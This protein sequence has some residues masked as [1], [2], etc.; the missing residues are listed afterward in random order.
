MNKKIINMVIT[1][2][3]LAGMLNATSVFAFPI[4]TDWS[5][6]IDSGF[7]SWTNSSNSTI[8]TPT[9][10]VGTGITASDVN[11][12]LSDPSKLSWGTGTNGQSSLSVG[13]ASGGNVQ[14]NLLTDAAAVNTVKLIHNNQPING[15]TLT[16]AVLFDQIVL[17]ATAPAG[18]VGTLTPN[19]TL[20]FLIN[21]VE[22]PNATP[23]VAPSPSGNPCNDI[24]V[25]DVQ[26]AGFNP[27]NQ[28][29]NQNF[30]YNG[31]PYNAQLFIS[32]LNFLTAAECSTAGSSNSHCLGF[33][34]IEG[35]SNNFQ[36]SLAITTEQF[37]P[38]PEPSILLL[39]GAGLCGMGW[40]NSR[41]QQA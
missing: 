13:S 30:F 36:V 28:S 6:T 32:G 2:I 23:C 5:Y 14:G 17:N 40:M 29:L 7:T 25:L 9:S 39:F 18:S 34:T 33:T 21:Y 19:Q 10:N 15:T 37:F 1:T 24:F 16:S 3:A 20:N 11:T 35:L 4:V 8:G 12:L 26:G 22:T 38:V 27:A 31:N 41:R